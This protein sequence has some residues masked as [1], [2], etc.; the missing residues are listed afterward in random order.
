MEVPKR[1]YSKPL[2][3][4]TIVI[5]GASSGAGRAIA[6]E[7]ARRGAKLVVSARRLQPL[8]ELAAECESY[9]TS[10]L[11]I[12][13]DVTDADALKELATAAQSWGGTMDVWVNNAGLL[14]AGA[15]E[16][17]PIEV[18]QKVIQTNLIGYVNGAHAA[19]PLFKRQGF[20][21][22]V[23]NISVGGWFP[24]PYAAAYSASKFGLRGFSESLKGE[25]HKFPHIHV[26]DLFPAFLDTPGIQHAANYTGSV[27]RPAPP[28]YDP[29]RVA[30]AVARLVKHPR[31]SVTIG[32]ITTLLKWAYAL[33]PKLSRN[34]TAHFMET[35]FKNADKIK[36][37]SGNVLETVEYG[38][39]VHGG[40][41][42]QPTQKRLLVKSLLAAGILAG[43]ALFGRK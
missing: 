12:A 39:S 14:A 1:Q 37:S 5:T 11:P 10:V 26:C 18:H 31:S 21:I 20:G 22:I 29:Q 9:G 28:L 6:L 23:N 35:Y 33:S 8:E 30:K 2:A 32:S 41:G 7:L 24:T 13:A 40:W 42:M 3:G 25:L 19:L 43:V 36:T 4:K 38:T 27:L 17:T 15:F 34:A 16:K